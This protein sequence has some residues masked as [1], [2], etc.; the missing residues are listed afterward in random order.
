M[1]GDLRE[2]IE[3][4]ADQDTVDPRGEGGLDPLGRRDV[5]DI[6]LA[7]ARAGTTVFFSSHELSEGELVCDH[8]AIL[9]KGRVV[10]EGAAKEMVKPGQSLEKYFMDVVQSN[11]A[12]AGT[13]PP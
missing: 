12:A 3:G 10:A 1:S 8:I 13:S 11:A 6:I 4:L 5:R 9:A 2:P 7:Q